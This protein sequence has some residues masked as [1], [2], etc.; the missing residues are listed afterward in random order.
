LIGS[1]Q[2]LENAR[3]EFFGGVVDFRAV[4]FGLGRQRKAVFFGEFSAFLRRLTRGSGR[5]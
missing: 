1:V 3:L 2:R 5:V 4:I